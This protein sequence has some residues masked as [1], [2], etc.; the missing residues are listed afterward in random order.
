M[1]LQ[2]SS[3]KIQAEPWAR[4]KYYITPGIGANGERVTVLSC[5]ID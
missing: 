3:A 4:Y 2:R 5:R 1:K